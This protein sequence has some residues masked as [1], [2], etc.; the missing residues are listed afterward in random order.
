MKLYKKCSLSIANFQSFLIISRLKNRSLI[1]VM[2]MSFL[3]IS[4]SAKA[5][6]IL[7]KEQNILSSCNAFKTPTNNAK[8]LPCMN[9]IEGF[10]NGILNAN[11]TDVATL[12]EDNQKSATLVERAYANRAGNKTQRNSKSIDY[13]C[14]SMDKYKK[15]IIENL[16]NSSLSTIHSLKQLNA[17]LVHV[18]KIACDAES[19]RE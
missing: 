12:L 17:R 6:D 1:I 2:M 10:L 19:K 14:L 3:S 4:S 5:V 18:L 8:T 11:N 7:D 15:H 16:S 13:A 9:Y